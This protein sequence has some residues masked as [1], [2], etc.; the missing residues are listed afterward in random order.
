M[1]HGVRS[2]SMDVPS[3]QECTPAPCEEGADAPCWAHEFEDLLFGE[4]SQPADAPVR[5]AEN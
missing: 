5:P 3:R 1:A 4:R 2:R